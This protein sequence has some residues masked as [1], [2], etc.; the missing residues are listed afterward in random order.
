MS[1]L[2]RVEQGHSIPELRI[3]PQLLLA[4]NR[5]AKALQNRFEWRRVKEKGDG[6]MTLYIVCGDARIVTA[7]IFDGPKIVSISSIASSG[8]LRPFTYLLRHSMVGQIVVVGHF[9]H[10]KINQTG[11]MAGCGGID[12]S[13]KLKAGEVRIENEDLDEYLEHRV[14]PKFFASVRSIVE[15]AGLIS[16]K[17]VLGTLVDHLTYGAFPIMELIGSKL[18]KYPEGYLLKFQ[19][20]QI[21]YL[22]EFLTPDAGVFPELKLEDLNPVFQNIIS[23][24]RK[25]AMKRIE[26]DPG[27]IERQRI[28]NPSTV[29][30]STCPM[31]LALRYPDTFGKPNKAFVIRQPFVKKGDGLDFSIEDVNFKSIVGQIYYPLSHALMN[32]PKKGFSDTRDLLIETPDLELSAQIANR[33]IGVQFIKDWLSQRGGKIMIGEVKEERTTQVQD[34]PNTL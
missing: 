31:P 12:T 30:I 32:D 23:R 25:K 4:D 22:K 18:I 6:Q 33:L 34:F 7:E 14:S 2:R 10:E 8:D 9:D 26:K 21:K 24:N 17:P 28:Q 15:E 20:G 5:S 16:G 19:K 11:K 1:V 27:F 3:F 13:K 29:V